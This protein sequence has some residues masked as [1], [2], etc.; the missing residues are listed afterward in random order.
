MDTWAASSQRSTAPPPNLVSARSGFV[1]ALAGAR[2][3]TT[4][5]QRPRLLLLGT[6]DSCDA[7]ERC[8]TCE[9][10]ELTHQI[11]SKTFE[12]S[13]VFHGLPWGDRAIM[14]AMRR[15]RWHAQG[16]AE[17]RPWDRQAGP[18]LPILRGSAGRQ[19]DR[20][21]A[22]GTR[23]GTHHSSAAAGRTRPPDPRGEVRRQCL[24]LRRGPGR[25][26]PAAERMS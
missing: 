22:E 15:R 7:C 19:W 11:I 23:E 3:I 9:T 13:L 17:A 20:V 25:F 5:L 12:K 16:A 14:P 8:D 2:I 10:C 24:A 6:C 26:L 4:R 1:R 21:A 18:G